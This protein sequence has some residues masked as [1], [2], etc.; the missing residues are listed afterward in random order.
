M[1][2]FSKFKLKNAIIQMLKNHNYQHVKGEDLHKEY[3]SV[4]IFDDLKNY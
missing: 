4:L 2:K 3:D 1:A